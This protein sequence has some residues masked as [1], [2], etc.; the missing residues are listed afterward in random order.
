MGLEGPTVPSVTV[1]RESCSGPL[2]VNVS[3]H[4]APAD[5]WGCTGGRGIKTLLMAQDTCSQGQACLLTKA[6]CWVES[7][8]PHHRAMFS[9]GSPTQCRLD[10][11]QLTQ[12]ESGH[13]DR[14]WA[15]FGTVVERYGS[16]MSGPPTCRRVP[17]GQTPGTLLV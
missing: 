11:L 13:S 5:L 16:P 8:Q 4:V 6:L 17:G 7:S 9:V 3:I 10:A 1:Q 14:V 2:G 12:M 15:G